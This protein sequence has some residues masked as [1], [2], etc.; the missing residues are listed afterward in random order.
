M[1]VMSKTLNVFISFK[2]V[3]GLH[4][5]C[6]YVSAIIILDKKVIL[7]RY[8]SF[9]I[10]LF[11]NWGQCFHEKKVVRCFDTSRGKVILHLPIKSLLKR[12]N[13]FYYWKKEL[14]QS[15]LEQINVIALY[16]FFIYTY[17]FI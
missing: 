5:K 12:K 9:F 17:S 7:M 13:D 15:L 8:V 4:F 2:L 10:L 11:G 14:F 6:S 16:N 1:N 3:K